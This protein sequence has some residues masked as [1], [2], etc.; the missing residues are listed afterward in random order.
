MVSVKGTTRVLRRAATRITTKVP[1]GVA[2]GF[3]TGKL[4]GFCA[5]TWSMFMCVSVHQN[6]KA[7]VQLQNH[8]LGWCLHEY[9]NNSGLFI[10]AT[11]HHQCACQHQYEESMHA[12][13]KTRPSQRP[14]RRPKASIITILGVAHTMFSGS[15]P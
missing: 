14:T 3:Y 8:E 7:H 2:T 11:C 13:T 12:R 15:L 1:I 9:I 6:M 10:P 4:Y 5:L